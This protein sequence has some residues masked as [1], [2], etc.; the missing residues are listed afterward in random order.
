MKT[1]LRVVLSLFM[2][3]LATG[4]ALAEDVC[5]RTPNWGQPPKFW[6]QFT[7]V[8]TTPPTT[9]A[10]RQLEARYDG[11]WAGASQVPL[12]SGDTTSRARIV[13]GG[14]GHQYLSIELDTTGTNREMFWVAYAPSSA[15]DSSGATMIE[16]TVRPDPDP[17]A[18]DPLTQAIVQQPLV[19]A[20]VTCP[21]NGGCAGVTP[22]AA[23]A[24][25]SA[26]YR[27]LRGLAPAGGGGL[28]RFEWNEQAFSDTVNVTWFASGSRAWR[29][30]LNGPNTTPTGATVMLRI[31]NAA[32]FGAA[33]PSDAKLWVATA[34]CT[35]LGTGP[36][37][38]AQQGNFPSA[39]IV[40][41]DA[42]NPNIYTAPALGDWALLRRA[43]LASCPAMT[44]L[45]QAGIQ[46]G[47][48]FTTAYVPGAPF[49]Y[50]QHIQLDNNSNSADD[51]ANH[52]AARITTTGAT[53]VG[54]IKA[55]F[56]VADWGSQIGNLDVSQWTEIGNV[57]NATG[58]AGAGTFD[59]SYQW[60][61]QSMS[62]ADI[63]KLACKYS[64]CTSATGGCPYPQPPAG[65][66][67]PACA[68]E[69]DKHKH[70]PHQCTQ[71]RLE[72]STYQLANDSMIFNTDFVGASVFWRVATI[73]TAGIATVQPP[74]AAAPAEGR[75]I[76]IHVV[77][78]NMTKQSNEIPAVIVAGRMGDVARATGTPPP[79]KKPTR[80]VG[81]AK[82]LRELLG[83]D[84]DNVDKQR[85]QAVLTAVRKLPLDTVRVIAPTLEFH[86]YY[87]TGRLLDNA[88]G[89]PSRWIEKMTSFRYVVEHIGAIK[90]WEWA[91]DGAEPLGN[92]WFRI[93]LADG[94]QQDIRTRLQAVEDQHRMP[95]GNPVWPP[96]DG[97]INRPGKPSP[98]KVKVK[99]AG[100]SVAGDDA[101]GPASLLLVLAG[102]LWL[103][104]RRRR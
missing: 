60:P 83:Q 10:L 47:A 54:K 87:D 63:K 7:D 88:G 34:T 38:C 78:N 12:T 103:G 82:T 24:A 22:C 17:G 97:W 56:Y 36:T 46:S 76:L 86:V 11:R 75:E 49:T 50:P 53:D 71:V 69:P 25:R 41:V 93:R 37:F 6:E 94:K 70:H 64:K 96:G 77:A 80:E 48:T 67:N 21:V 72:S 4:T 98:V 65:G 42:A 32:L 68:S 44:T 13:D 85:Q 61:P 27:I 84:N 51:K 2:L 101:S 14:D 16:V 79:G 19:C 73:S 66:D 62:L 74:P 40:A 45:A 57:D 9:R 35:F 29:G 39:G 55:R 28:S 3:S 8:T 92:N 99:K 81:D 20:A 1:T 5:P 91:L 43:T 90:G 52:F 89:K 26:S 30:S 102:M 15:P 18:G 23:P 95:G 33:A 100:C 58:T 104:R 31:P 59:I